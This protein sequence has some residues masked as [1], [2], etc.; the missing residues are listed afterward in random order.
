MRVQTLA[1]SIVALSAICLTGCTKGDT[2]PRKPETSTLDLATTKAKLP[3]VIGEL[4]TYCQPFIPASPNGDM[5]ADTRGH[6]EDSGAPEAIQQDLTSAGF[7][8]EYG[9]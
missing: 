9:P 8:P 4:D 7:T 2:T 6:L 1:I 5:H 3:G